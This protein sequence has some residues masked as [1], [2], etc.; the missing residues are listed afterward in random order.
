MYCRKAKLKLPLKS[1]LEEY[2]CGKTRLFSVLEDSEDPVVK[3]V[4]PTI[5]TGRKWKVV[6]TVDEAKVCLQIKEVIGQT[7]TIRKELGSSR[8]KWWSKAEG[9]GKRDMVINEIRVH[10]DSRRVQKA[11]HQPQQGQWTNWDNALQK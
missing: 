11:V 2:K 7:Q 1:I 10:E 9:K 3:T 6:E 8:A 5:K 4:Q